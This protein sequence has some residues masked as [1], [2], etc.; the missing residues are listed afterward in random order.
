MKGK[1]MALF[2]CGFFCCQGGCSLPTTEEIRQMRLAE[3][4]FESKEYERSREGYQGLLQETLVP[5][6]QAVLTYDI[7]NV[8][9]AEGKWQE[10]IQTLRA[11]PFDNELQ[12]LL[13]Y[14]VNRNLILAYLQQVESTQEFETAKLSLEQAGKEITQLDANYC[15]LERAR[16]NE[17]CVKDPESDLFSSLLAQ[18][19]AQL[20]QKEQ[21]QLIKKISF[22]EGLKKLENGTQMILK[23]IALMEQMGVKDGLKAEYQNFYASELG[24]WMLFWEILKHKLLANQK[25]P[26][27]KKRQELYEEAYKLFSQGTQQFKEQQLESS[28]KA[29]QHSLEI[30]QA[31]LLIPPP[32]SEAPVTQEPQPPGQEERSSKPKEEKQKEQLLQELLQMNREDGMPKKEGPSIEH[33]EEK[34]W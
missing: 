30:I 28:K 13:R 22:Q 27:L 32:P 25:D 12:S 19:T 15:Q 16:G 34:P 14:R 9:L 18:Q 24:T 5:W 20:K 11:V 7:G 31:L 23:E 17:G 10:A 1:I 6:Q 26:S 4:L 29:F 33:K 8:Y 21:E 3:A 2:F